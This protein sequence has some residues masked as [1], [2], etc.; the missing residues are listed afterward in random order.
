[1]GY[2]RLH[3]PWALILRFIS[4][5]SSVDCVYR[6]PGG[7]FM[8]VVVATI[9]VMVGLSWGDGLPN[10]ASSRTSLFQVASIITTTGFAS[11]DFERGARLRP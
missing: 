11:A 4:S 9:L 7:G 1:M 3:A 2:H 6:R 5:P 8:V 10:E